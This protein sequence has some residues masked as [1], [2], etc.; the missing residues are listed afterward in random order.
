MLVKTIESSEI[1]FSNWRYSWCEAYN[2]GV[3]TGEGLTFIEL[4]SIYHRDVQVL[5][6]ILP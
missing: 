5:S 2:T 1:V 3:K 6:L 4:I